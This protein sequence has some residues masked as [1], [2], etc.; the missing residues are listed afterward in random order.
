M[1]GKAPQNSSSHTICTLESPAGLGGGHFEQILQPRPQPKL[2]PRSGGGAEAQSFLKLPQDIL[3]CRQFG[4]QHPG[5]LLLE[6]RSSAQQPSITWELNRKADLLNQHLHF[7][8]M[9]R[10]SVCTLKFEKPRGRRR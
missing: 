3:M 7:H 9:P 5:I 10:R 6:L 2:N 8:K 4:N 1:G